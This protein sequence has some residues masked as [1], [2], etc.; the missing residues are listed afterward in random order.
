MEP[1]FEKLDG[2]KDAISGYTGGLLENPT[3]EEVSSGNTEHLESVKIVY[4]PKII[5]YEELLDVF[6]RQIDPT[7]SGGQFVDRGYQYTSAIFYATEEE[8][9]LAEKSLKVLDESGKYN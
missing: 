9:E 3:Y 4:D 2:V 5:S 8:K 1:P 6:W 7:D